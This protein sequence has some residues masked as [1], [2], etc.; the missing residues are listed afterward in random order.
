MN[1]LLFVPAI[2]I[3]NISRRD[4]ANVRALLNR[5]QTVAQLPTKE[6]QAVKSQLQVYFHLRKGDIVQ[7][8]DRW[9]KS[10]H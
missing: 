6:L 4:V 2:L 7:A 5:L 10:N 3:P 8:I 9:R 1:S